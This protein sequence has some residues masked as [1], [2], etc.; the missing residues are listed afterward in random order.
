ML[1]LKY[2]S[3]LNKFNNVNKVNKFQKNPLIKIK[4]N[5]QKDTKTKKHQIS[6]ADG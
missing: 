6:Q 4:Y 1:I 2:F 5:K 3:K